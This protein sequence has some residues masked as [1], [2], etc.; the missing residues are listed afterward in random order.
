M[1]LTPALLAIACTATAFAQTAEFKIV[2]TGGMAK[3]GYYAPQ[4]T[5]FAAEKPATLT[6]APEGLE[7][8]QYGILGMAG[9]EGRTFHFIIDEPDGKPAKLFV[10]TN[11]NGDLTD[12]P[13]AEWAG[14]ENKGADGATTTMYNGAA[15]VDI[16]DA[17]TPLVVGVSMYRF[18]KNDPRRAA[19]KTT[20]LYYRDYAYEGTLTLGGKTYKGVLSDESASGDFRGKPITGP[21]GASGVMLLVD[22]NNNGKFD[23]K[24]ESFDIRKPF[25]IG[26]ESWTITNMSRTGATFGVA[27]SAEKV[28]AVGLPPDHTVGKPITAFTAKNTAGANV[29]FPADYKGKIVL[30]DFWAT[31]CGP[32]MVEMPNVVAAY[33]KYHSQG[34]EVLGISLDSDKSITKMPAV[35]DKAGMVWPQIADGKYWEAEIAVLYTV[36]SI[37]ATFLVDGDTG[38]IIGM[39]LRGKALD[40]AVEK[41]LREKKAG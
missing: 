19:L 24:G 27:V 12:D 22:V 34:F 28:A 18:D 16:G 6:K 5:T 41:A 29:N 11:G 17:G 40:E 20:L 14:K 26:G 32:C 1:N 30:L 3:V 9:A 10:D 35:M 15:K 36:Q 31:W 33:G 13:A 7:A 2:P 37:P 4:R 8:P 25:N 23:S 21:K 39:N 38:K